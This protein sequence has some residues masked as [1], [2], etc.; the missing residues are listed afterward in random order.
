MLYGIVPE[1]P[2]NN[3]LFDELTVCLRT[4]N[5]RGQVSIETTRQR[6]TPAHCWVQAESLRPDPIS[7]MTCID[8]ETCTTPGHELEVGAAWSDDTAFFIR[9][10]LV[11]YWLP[12]GIRKTSFLV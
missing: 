5:D 10:T 3:T 12:V 8:S 2:R 6:H 7:A 9:A 11:V 1:I 4:M